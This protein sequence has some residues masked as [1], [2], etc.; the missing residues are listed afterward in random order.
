MESAR[1]PAAIAPVHAV[2]FSSARP[3]DPA[4][5]G[6]PTVVANEGSQSAGKKK[7]SDCTVLPTANSQNEGRFMKLRSVG[8][9]AFDVVTGK[10]PLTRKRHGGRAI[11][12]C[13]VS[14]SPQW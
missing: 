9:K 6:N 1:R 2:R 10:R 12:C 14:K 13:I 7:P 11:A 8:R 4:E 3:S 5:V